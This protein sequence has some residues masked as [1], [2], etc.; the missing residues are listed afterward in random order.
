MLC[1]SKSKVEIKRFIDDTFTFMSQNMC[2]KFWDDHDRCT[3][4]SC[5]I[6]G[7]SLYIGCYE[8]NDFLHENRDLLFK[9]GYPKKKK[10]IEII[11]KEGIFYS[12]GS[13]KGEY[14]YLNG[15]L[16]FEGYRQSFED[17]CDLFKS[18]KKGEWELIK[19]NCPEWGVWRP[20][21]EKEIVCKEEIVEYILP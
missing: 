7:G 13:G 14:S 19:S 8:F 16:S 15:V 20:K 17:G 5:C 18:S 11:K 9:N 4:N 12:T 10:T 6:G 3:C 1:E 21:I 2:S